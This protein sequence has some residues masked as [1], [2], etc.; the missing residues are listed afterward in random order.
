[1]RLP[2]RCRVDIFL[3]RCVSR[4]GFIRVPRVLCVGSK[5]N[6][7]LRNQK[8]GL[9]PWQCFSHHTRSRFR[10]GDRHQVR[11]PT[12]CKLILLKRRGERHRRRTLLQS[13]YLRPEHLRPEQLH[14]VHL[15]PV[16][17]CPVHLCPVHLH[18]VLHNLKFREAYIPSHSSL[19]LH[20]HQITRI[21]HHHQSPPPPQQ[22]QHQTSLVP[23]PPTQSATI[24]TP[25]PLH[26]P[27]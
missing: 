12:K 11:N 1:V 20:L 17:L 22:H 7:M 27:H 21:Q 9:R 23:H 6:L 18:P 13:V 25:E 3:E 8:L 10:R 19:F 2:W 14:S 5:W 4:N 24:P 26:P 16:H 15:R